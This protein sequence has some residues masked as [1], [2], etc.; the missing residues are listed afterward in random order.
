[1]VKSSRRKLIVGVTEVYGAIFTLSILGFFSNYS[2][3]AN[4]ANL[5]ELALTIFF[6]LV[7]LA[8][9]PNIRSEYPPIYR[10]GMA[11][12]LPA[13]IINLARID[14]LLSAYNPHSFNIPL[15]RIDAIYFT[16]TTLSTVGFGDIRP[17]TEQA[18]LYV[19]IQIIV[20]LVITIYVIGK[21]MT[22]NHRAKN[23]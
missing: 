19:T 14:L 1:M 22:F 21:M 6:N 13:V 3:Q 7:P 8:V 17:V 15:T 16:I 4:Y 11:L 20:G 5:I 10:I 18:R 9:L 2:S 12:M 23:A